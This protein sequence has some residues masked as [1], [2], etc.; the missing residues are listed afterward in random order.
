MLVWCPRD[1]L[2][3]ESKRLVISYDF[4]G[5]VISL[6]ILLP[7]TAVRLFLTLSFSSHESKEDESDYILLLWT[8]S[9]DTEWSKDAKGYLFF[10]MPMLGTL[11]RTL[12]AFYII[13][14]GT[15]SEYI[16][17]KFFR[18]FPFFRLLRV[19]PM[20]L[21]TLVYARFRL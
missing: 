4:V 9:S 20:Y 16:L 19:I 3:D 15:P 11:N 10:K 18:A 21:G 8:L 2:L 7:P 17:Q 12:F 5:F 1:T 14:F 13:I 6:L